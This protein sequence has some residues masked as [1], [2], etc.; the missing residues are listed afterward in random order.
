MVDDTA[1]TTWGYGDYRAMAAR[2]YP[3]AV[4]AIEAA[5]VSPGDRVV[6]IATGTGNAALLAAARGAEVVGV[7]FEPALLRIAATRAAEHGGRIQWLRGD[8]GDLPLPD[9]CA[10]VVVSVF[11]VMYASD[12]DAAVAEIARI[13]GRGARIVLASWLPGGTLPAMGRILAPYL[14]PP[15]AGAP[16]SRWGDPEALAALLQPQR[17]LITASTRERINLRFESPSAGADFLIRTAGHV[18]HER[19]ALIDEGRWDRL[20]TDLAD[21]VAERA[22]TIDGTIELPLDYLLATITNRHIS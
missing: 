12:H 14:P 22:E 21:F 6:D 20:H 1:A 11:G 2:L 19:Q 8:V 4:A 10:D 16:P 5:A 15:P 13:A 7:D 18:M 9:A 3:A 17:M